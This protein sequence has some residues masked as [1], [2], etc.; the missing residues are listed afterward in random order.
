MDFLRSY[1][2]QELTNYIAQLCD[3]RTPILRKVKTFN[4]FV[5][6]SLDADPSGHIGFLHYDEIVTTLHECY[7][8]SNV[9]VMAYEDVRE[10]EQLFLSTLLS[11]I[12]AKYD[13][14]LRLGSENVSADKF[15]GMMASAKDAGL[16]PDQLENL[17]IA[18]NALELDEFVAPRLDEFL[19]RHVTGRY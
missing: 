13:P 16:T 8:H 7:G 11:F 2:R 10:D 4:S 3:G 15:S 12:G 17:A 14:Q 18:Y 5:R 9:L 19:Q 6:S 1:Y